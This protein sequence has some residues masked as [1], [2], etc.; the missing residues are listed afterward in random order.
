[1]HSQCTAAHRQ[2]IHQVLQ[3]FVD[4][5]VNV[6]IVTAQPAENNSEVM[7]NL[8]DIKGLIIAGEFGLVRRWGTGQ[9][10]REDLGGFDMEKYGNKLQA[11]I[12]GE[13]LR[14]D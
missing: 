11:C 14:N 4:Q 3:S 2:G 8:Q 13:H 7:K 1:M 6:I 5:G 10:E 12:Q 9:I